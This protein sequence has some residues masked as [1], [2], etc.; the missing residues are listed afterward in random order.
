MLAQRRVDPRAPR[1]AALI[2][3]R[4]KVGIGKLFEPRFER[5][6]LAERCLKREQKRRIEW[7]AKHQRTKLRVGFG[8]PGA[9]VRR[10]DCITGA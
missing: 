9:D 10:A 4:R 2:M 3:E 5:G 1:G 6:M 8:H 7:R